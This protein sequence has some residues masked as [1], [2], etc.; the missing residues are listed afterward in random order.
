[1]IY[2]I[3]N[4]LPCFTIVY[5]ILP[6]F[7]VLYHVLPCF[8]FYHVLPCFAFQ[9]VYTLSSV[10]Y[11]ACHRP[12]EKKI[13]LKEFFVVKV[14]SPFR[15]FSL[16]VNPEKRPNDLYCCCFIF[17]FLRLHQ[18]YPSICRNLQTAVFQ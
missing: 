15:W 7:A 9:V 12:D 1:M 14:K 8:T 3:C 13:V 18:A 16:F 2:H 6:C 17:C 5:H 10:E 11:G 4:V